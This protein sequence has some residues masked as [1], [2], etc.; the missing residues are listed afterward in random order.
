V[1]SASGE[2]ISYEKMVNIHNKK[3]NLMGLA[4]SNPWQYIKFRTL[5]IRNPTIAAVGTSRVMQFRDY[6]F[7]EPE[8]FYNAGGIVSS[9]FD[10]NLLIKELNANQIKIIIMGLDQYFFNEYYDNGIG[11]TELYT[12]TQY[13]TENFIKNKINII[14]YT[15]V[16]PLLLK[17]EIDFKR[18]FSSENIGLTA[19]MYNEGFRSDGSY[20][21]QRFINNPEKDED[22]NFQNTFKRIEKGNN[23]FEYSNTVYRKALLEMNLFLETCKRKNIYVIAFLPPYASA[24]WNKMKSKPYEYKYLFDLYKELR[25]IFN[26]HSFDLYDFGDIASLGSTDDEAIG[27]FHGS[28]V[29]Y[30]RMMIKMSLKNERLKDYVNLNVLN[31][32]LKNRF[33]SREIKQEQRNQ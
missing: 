30:L 14:K 17:G 24:V 13:R 23:R 18:L 2:L 4:F 27:G 20:Y 6:F 15:T 21:Y 9:I 19:K 16:I 11:R 25:P 8:I 12:V 1:L 3:D 33:G 28:E 10:L 26:K 5:E 32:L 31:E 7:I 29:T 22:F